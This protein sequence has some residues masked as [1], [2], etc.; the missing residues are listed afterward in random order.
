MN[1]MNNFV[2]DFDYFLML[3]VSLSLLCKTIS[4]SLREAELYVNEKKE[5]ILYSYSRVPSQEN[6]CISLL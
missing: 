3:S 4:S 5:C 2:K 6:L 1:V